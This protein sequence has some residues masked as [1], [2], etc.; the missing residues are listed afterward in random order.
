MSTLTQRLTED[1]RAAMKA[2]DARRTG[3][4]R[5]VLGEIA[6]KERAGKT[7]V[8]FTDEQV[9]A[10]LRSEVKKRQETAEVYTKAGR[11]ELATVETEEAVILNEY[12]PAMLS[13]E[14][15]T[16]VVDETIQALG[17]APNIGR[18]MKAVMEKV[19][20]Q[21]DGRTVSGIVRERLG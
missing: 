16:Q 4:L 12:L 7:A 5:Y 2:R 3:V 19:G 17:E 15:I 18:V 20:T 9:I 8:V 10:L 13:V 1:M 11:D 6:T 14:Q 21:A